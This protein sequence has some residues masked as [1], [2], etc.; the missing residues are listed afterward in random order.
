MKAFCIF[1][2]L[3]IAATIAMAQ[4]N[5]S[6]PAKVTGKGHTTSDDL[7]YWDLKVGDGAV[8][9]PGKTVVVNYSGYLT[10]G[11]KFDSSYDRS[12]PFQFK[13]GNGEVIK[14]WDEGV[15]GMKVG[16]RRQLKIPSTLAYGSQGVPGAIPPNATLIF[17]VELL[18]VK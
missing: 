17:D 11:K 15:A 16:G 13:L 4:S 3:M 6:G 5:S 12:Q 18:A 1:A 7:Q 8:A 14:G 2:A 10:N 9:T